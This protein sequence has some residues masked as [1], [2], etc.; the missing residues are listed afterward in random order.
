MKIVSDRLTVRAHLETV[1]LLQCDPGVCGPALLFPL[2]TVFGYPMPDNDE[3]DHIM[4]SLVQ[5][6]ATVVFSFFLKI[7]RASVLLRPVLLY[8][9]LSCEFYSINHTSDIYFVL[10]Y[11]LSLELLSCFCFFLF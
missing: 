3:Q 7:S 8:F 6:T 5:T 11:C 1:F 10:F 9:R 2:V 4:K